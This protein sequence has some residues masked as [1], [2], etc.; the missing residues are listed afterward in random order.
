MLML[1][2]SVSYQNDQN[3]VVSKQLTAVGREGER[4]G[5]YIESVDV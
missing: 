3:G 5:G 2:V 1:F 4:V